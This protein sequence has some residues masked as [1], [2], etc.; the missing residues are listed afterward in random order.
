MSKKKMLLR[1]LGFAFSVLPPLIATFELFPLM[2]SA[3][4]VSVLAILAIVL[5]CVP[6]IKHLKRIMSSPSAWLMWLVVFMFCLVL[7]AVIDE[8]YTISMLGFLGSLIG[9]GFF[10]L[11]KRTDEKEKSDG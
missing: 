4:K 5:S 1:I 2:T 3:G 7:K 8:F 6:F 10:Y 11:A 9:A